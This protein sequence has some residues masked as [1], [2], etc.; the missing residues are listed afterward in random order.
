VVA[1]VVIVGAGD[2]GRG[3]VMEAGFVLQQCYIAAGH[4]TN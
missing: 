2:G 4:H 1:V 3:D